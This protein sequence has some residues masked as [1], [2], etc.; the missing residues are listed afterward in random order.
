MYEHIITIPKNRGFR[1]TA[2][3]PKKSPKRNRR[4]NRQRDRKK[5]RERNCRLLNERKRRILGRIVNRPGPERDQ[6]MMTATNIH[7]ELADRVQGLSAGGIGAMLTLAQTD[8]AD[9]RH[10]LQG[11][12][13]QA[14]FALPRIRPRPEYRVQHHGRWQ[15]D[16]AHRTAAQR[17][18]LSRCP[19]RR[20][21][22]RP[23]HR[24]GFLPPLPW[25]P[26]SWT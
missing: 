15:A 3:L 6:P 24:R 13:P 21:C 23:D 10:R 16:R 19:G 7:Y 25:V 20:A 2:T 5:T 1:V 9:P 17:R 26:R 11:P 8:R 12:C 4:K 18:G 22:P 14:A